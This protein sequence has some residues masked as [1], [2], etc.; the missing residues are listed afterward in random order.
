MKKK[1]SYIKI[2]VLSGMANPSPPVGPVLGQ[3]G[4]NIMKFCN[5]FNKKTSNLEKGIP[6]PVII[7][8]FNDRTFDFIIKNPPI[9]FLLKKF[10]SIDKGSKNPG[11]DI[12]A[13]INI[14]DIKD[15]AKLKILDTNSYNI[16]S[17]LKSIIGTAKSMGIKINN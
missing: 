3:R 13:N 2:Q 10:L 7:R 14:K 4:L 12:I 9:S 15:I 8:V 6:I 11:K 5:D 17:V 1:L 16:D